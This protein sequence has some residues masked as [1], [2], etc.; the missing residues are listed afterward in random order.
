MD[1]QSILRARMEFN[2]FLFSMSFPDIVDY[3]ENNPSQIHNVEWDLFT[4]LSIRVSKRIDDYPELILKHPN[5]DWKF[6][7]KQIQ[8]E[9]SRKI[10]ELSRYKNPT[11]SKNSNSTDWIDKL[12]ITMEKLYILQNKEREI[13]D[14]K[15]SKKIKDEVKIITEKIEEKIEENVEEN[16]EENIIKQILSED[17]PPENIDDI[18]IDKFYHEESDQS[19]DYEDYTDY[20]ESY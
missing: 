4:N 12:V 7:I 1:I 5:W 18:E 8:H 10:S 6:D 3:I 2:D 14:S 17:M 16:V 9:L 13:L 19:D 15:I 20:S 11:V